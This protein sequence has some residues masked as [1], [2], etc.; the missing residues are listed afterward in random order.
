MRIID[1]RE[2]VVPIASEIRNAFIDF[3]TR[4]GSNLA[5]ECTKF[6]FEG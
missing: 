1:I 6:G 4:H 5:L 2:A 3:S